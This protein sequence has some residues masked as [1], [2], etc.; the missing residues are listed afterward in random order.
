MAGAMRDKVVVLTGAS[1]GIGR[2]TATRLARRGASLVLAARNVDALDDVRQEC[3]ALGGLALAVPTD[4]SDAAQVAD[5]ARRAVARFG[6][7]DVWVN[8]AAVSTVGRLE[9]LPVDEIRRLLD[10]NVLGYVLGMQEALRLFR[11][12]DHGTIVN[13]SSL[14]A[15]VG[16]PYQAPYVAS[17]HA[18]HGLGE[19]VRMEL[20]GERRIHVCCVMPGAIDTPFFQHAANHTGRE[21]KAPVP[22]IRPE[23][24]AR[25]VEGC[26][27][28]PRRERPVGVSTRL[29]LTQ[30]RFMPRVTEAVVARQMGRDQFG[31]GTAA[32]ASGNLFEPLPDDVRGGWRGGAQGLA[33]KAALAV[34]AAM[35]VKSVR[36]QLT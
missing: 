18:V 34:A 7:V 24:V 31:P 21:V 11:A 12:Q 29:L 16:T 9:D 25:A 20:Q 32:H 14:V 26:I 33:R 3:E 36:R 5:L 28:R 1:S 4:V 22:T 35:A 15:R 2:A 23:A 30:R 8:D 6:R 13:V 17:K 10:V 19:S 27:R